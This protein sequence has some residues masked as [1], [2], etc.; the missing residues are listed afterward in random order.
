MSWCKLQEW[1]RVP[2]GDENKDNGFW[3]TVSR[4]SPTRG[5]AT[6]RA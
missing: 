3:F 1:D 2:R 4:I 6:G 5:R